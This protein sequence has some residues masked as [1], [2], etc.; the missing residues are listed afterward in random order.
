MPSITTGVGRAGLLGLLIAA[1]AWLPSNACAQVVAPWE[2]DTYDPDWAAARPRRIKQFTYDAAVSDR[3]NGA[4]LAQALQTLEA[5]DQLR[6]DSG[7]YVITSKL[8]LDLQGTARAPIWIVGASPDN[9]PVITRPDARQNLVNVGERGP[10]RYLALQDLELTGGSVVIRFYDCAQVWLN[11]CEL[12]HGAHGG[13]TINSR[14][15]HHMY[16]TRNHF[17]HFLSGIASTFF[18]CQPIY[19][20]FQRTEVTASKFFS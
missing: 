6:I 8:T 19:S 9:P 5:G 4:R 3:H 16:V 17:H 10:C 2:R 18:S 12:H 20:T 14:D 15:T 13:I 7:Q 11:R 1:A